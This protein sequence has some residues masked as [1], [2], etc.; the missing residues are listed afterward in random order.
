MPV[1]RTSRGTDSDA[2]QDHII[3]NGSE[4][5]EQHRSCHAVQLL[6][7]RLFSISNDWLKILTIMSNQYIASWYKI[8]WMT[9][10]E[11][12]LRARPT[13]GPK[14]PRT[15]CRLPSWTMMAVIKNTRHAVTSEVVLR[16]SVVLLSQLCVEILFHNMLIFFCRV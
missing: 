8:S 10:P 2:H 1:H 11:V 9:I 15:H 12:L 7:V 4:G 14:L 6:P 16:L 5:H 3:D 13:S